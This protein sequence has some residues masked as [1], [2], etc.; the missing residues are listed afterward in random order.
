MMEAFSF[1]LISLVSLLPLYV[2]GATS[3]PELTILANKKVMN[4]SGTLG[5][6]IAPRLSKH[7]DSLP[8]VCLL[9]LVDRKGVQPAWPGQPGLQLIPGSSDSR[10]NYLEVTF[11]SSEA[12]LFDN[13]VIVNVSIFSPDSDGC[14]TDP[15]LLIANDT[16][17]L[18]DDRGT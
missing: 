15:D 13:P 17:L 7:K 5:V 11:D 3:L 8:D 12:T 4:I 9:V 6:T 2:E 18:Y 14:K 10:T 1:L 16:T